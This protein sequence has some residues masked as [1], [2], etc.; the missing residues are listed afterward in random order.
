MRA[1]LL[2]AIARRSLCS[3]AGPDASRFDAVAY[4]GLWDNLSRETWPSQQQLAVIGPASQEFTEAVKTCGEA[5]HGCTM[6]RVTT[7]P[8]S[9]WQSI[10]LSVLCETPDDFCSLHSRL[11]ALEGVKALV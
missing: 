6:L 4:R 2:V 8:K 3:R 7:E 9:R 5:T 11:S 10:R 1:T